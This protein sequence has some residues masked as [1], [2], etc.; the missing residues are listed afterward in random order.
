MARQM[1]ADAAILSV[2]V[3]INQVDAW[4]A[5]QEPTSEAGGAQTPPTIDNEHERL[6]AL[7]Q[8][9]LADHRHRSFDDVAKQVAEAFGAPIALVSLISD[10]Q[11]LMP[12]AEGLPPE[13][14]AARQIPREESVCGHVIATDEVVVAED[15]TKD[16]RFTDN[17]LVLEKGIRFYAGAPLRTSSGLVLGSL[18]VIDMQ[19]REFSDADRQRLQ[20]MADELM[21]QLERR[22]VGPADKQSLPSPQGQRPREGVGS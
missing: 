20:S 5:R 16:P 1:S 18:C 10:E 4:L 11:Q 15:V 14:N 12:G 13:L 17:P 22:S 8:L 21:V 9:G 2:E 19:P 6:A 3:C 7:Q